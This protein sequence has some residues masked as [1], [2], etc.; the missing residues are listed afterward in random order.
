MC[1]P[2]VEIPVSAIFKLGQKAGNAVFTMNG[3]R[4]VEAES[5]LWREQH[6]ARLHAGN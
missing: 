6:L 3:L 5:E 2:W 1:I 4:R